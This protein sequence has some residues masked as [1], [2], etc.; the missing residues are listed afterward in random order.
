MIAR[1]GDPKQNTCLVAVQSVT[2]ARIGGDHATAVADQHAR[3]A[4][5]AIVPSAILVGVEIHAS[6]DNGAIADACVKAQDDQADDGGE[7]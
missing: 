3:Q 6:F 2:A 7:E 1:H 4:R 5:F